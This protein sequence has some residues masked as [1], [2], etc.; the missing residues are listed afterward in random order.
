MSHA[1]EEER[2]TTFLELF[3]DLVL[4]F[5]ITQLASQLHDVPHHHAGHALQGWLEVG[6][7]ATMIWWLWSQFAWL[8]TSVHLSTTRPRALMLALTG[9][10]LVASVALPVAT[11]PGF[12][13]FGAAYAV[14]KFG[15]LMLYRMDADGGVAHAAAV[16]D[17]TRKAAIAP[18][19]VLVGAFLP[20]PARLVA[21]G[22]AMLIELGGT[23]LVG[24][25][26]FRI[27]AAHF[28][29]RHAL[30]LI[31]VLGEAV[32]AL[33]GKAVATALDTA[34]I[35]GLL[36][37]F[38]LVATL[39]WSYFAWTFDSAE[40]W[41]KGH[42]RP[43]APN[44]AGAA[45]RMARDAFT[46]GHFPLVAGVIAIAVALK[47]LAAEPLAAWH[48]EARVALAVGLVLYLGGFVGVVFR[49][50]GYLLTER[51]VAL[52]VM[53]SLALASPLPAGLTA[54]L[55]GLVLVIAIGAE[56]RRWRRL[57]AR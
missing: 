26:G 49:G 42:G 21:W 45:G 27:S 50:N 19:V 55:L 15:A 51:I 57:H 12:S 30:V 6:L 28:A 33:G 10:L 48:G 5:A 54:A 32:V 40:G 3:F 24:R 18:L 47:D 39:W 38:L 53:V 46:F 7:L 36:G 17:Y 43:F 9:V 2:R 44:D 29:E 16:R 11:A 52:V 8:G 41:L 35:L 4:V 14:V 37:G 25:Q 34:S 1:A 31:I 22:I 20:P 56:V 13:W 23:L